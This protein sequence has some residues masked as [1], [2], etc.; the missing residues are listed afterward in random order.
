[1][2]GQRGPSSPPFPSSH[3]PLSYT[4]RF[5][6]MTAVA[7]LCGILAGPTQSVA[8]GSPNSR[9]PAT[10]TSPQFES[11]GTPSVTNDARSG[12][13]PRYIVRVRTRDALETTVADEAATGSEVGAVMTD[14]VNG[15]VAALSGD[16]VRRLQND[17]NV[18]AIERD[19]AV[20]IAADQINPPWGLDRLDQAGLPLSNT[21]TY[22]T[23]GGGVTAYIVDTGIR[24]THNEFAGRIARGAYI[25]WG[26]GTGV[27]DCNGH[28]THVAGTIGGRTYGVAKSV[29]LVPMKVF[30]CSGTTQSS[31]VLV[32]LDWVV[33]DHLAGVPAVLNLSL[34]SVVSPAFDAAVNAVI[35]D[36]VT[37]VVAAGNEASDACNYSPARVAAA[38]TVG[39]TQVDDSVAGYSNYGPCLDL[40]APGSSVLSAWKTSDTSSAT[41]SGTSMATPHVTGAVARLLQARPADSP[42]QV[43]AALDA[44]STGGAIRATRSGDPNKL[45]H[46][47]P[48]AM[49]SP[50]APRRVSGVAG[51]AHVSLW[52]SAPWFDLGLPVFDYVVQYRPVGGSWSTF[53]DGMSAATAAT[54][55]G[56]ANETSYEFQV[57]A[58][59]AAGPGP[60]STPSAPLT[61]SSSGALSPALA[62]PPTTGFT[63]L[64]PVRLFDTRPDEPQ[65]VVPVLKTRYGGPDVLT[66]R[67]PGIIG[68]PL[69]GASAVSLNVTVVD[70]IA[71]GFV[72]VYP[73]GDRPSTSSLNFV[74]GQTVPNA[75]IAPLSAA[76][77]ICVFSSVDTHVIADI[78]GWF[79][80][81]SGFTA[82]PPARVFDTRPDEVQGAVEVSKQAYGDLKIKITGAAGVPPSGVDAVSLNVTVVNPVGLGVRHGVPVRRAPAD[83]EPQLRDRRDHAERSHRSRVAGR[84]DLLLLVGRCRPG[85]RCQRLVRRRTGLHRPASGPHFRHPARCPARLG[86]SQPAVLRRGERAGGE[87]RRGG[88]RAGIRRR[89][90]VAERDGGRSRRPGIRDGVSVRGAPTGLQPQLPHQRD[91]AE[92]SDRAGVT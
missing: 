15:F 29:Q 45:V 40:F 63:A 65:G 1:M 86:W 5:T 24:T 8:A 67:I 47:T 27:E 54:V 17:P 39:A 52:W 19:T 23:T 41:M 49:T 20:T 83:V 6:V 42:A 12:P 56:L 18:T 85:R 4:R 22:G 82:L 64:D 34:G 11:L 72:T 2:R 44:A 9:G 75:V 78:N 16:D 53:A 32:G 61:T 55:T 33:K 46:L 66:L 58:V 14:A 57:A 81:E 59:N 79:A 3:T 89:S 48:T 73:C 84:R 50:D 38:I 68:V 26:D 25:D 7:C 80:I 60:M 71:A 35:A 74:A 13:L 21:Y 69:S 43:W 10:A 36:G 90:G 30:A 62:P 88:G 70:P 77:E 51:N 91:R 92:R 37:V 87:D 31:S 28:G 76:G